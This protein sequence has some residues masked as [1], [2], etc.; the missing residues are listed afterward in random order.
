MN[1]SGATYMRVKQNLWEARE[2]KCA[3]YHKFPSWTLEY[4]RETRKESKEEKRK[5]E[6]EQRKGG[7]VEGCKEAEREDV[8]LAMGPEGYRSEFSQALGTL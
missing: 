2:Y 8:S 6:K 4:V 1:K 3:T 5:K 7:C